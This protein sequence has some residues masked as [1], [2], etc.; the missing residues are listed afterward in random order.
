MKTYLYRAS[1]VYHHFS[2]LSFMAEVNFWRP[3]NTVVS[4]DV[5]IIIIIII[6]F[7]NF[8]RWVFSEYTGANA[9]SLIP[10]DTTLP[11]K[12]AFII[13]FSCTVW[14]KMRSLA[15]SV[16]D[17]VLA[18]AILILP[19]PPPILPT[20]IWKVKGLQKSTETS[21]TKTIY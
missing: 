9:T 13:G 4:R 20:N 14:T 5:L 8:F 11:E 3:L 1:N 21:N 10:L 17:A 2:G 15:G 12:C 18:D 7:I 16:A 6:I 19:C